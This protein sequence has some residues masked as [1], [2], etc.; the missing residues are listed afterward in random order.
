M[1]ESAAEFEFDDA[2]E[3]FEIDRFKEE[4]G[5]GMRGEAVDVL[6][7]LVEGHAR[8]QDDGEAPAVFLKMAEDF[9]AVDARHL[10]IEEKDVDLT[11]FEV[12]QGGCAVANFVHVVA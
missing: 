3:R 6:L 1:V 10:E 4:R 11:V 7:D 2:Q 12:L 8:K 5:E 9:E